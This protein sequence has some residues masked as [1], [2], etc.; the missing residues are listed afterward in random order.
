MVDPVTRDLNNHLRDIDQA[1]LRDAIESGEVE[2][3][4]D[5]CQKRCRPGCRF[6]GVRDCRQAPA[7]NAHV[8]MI[9]R[10]I[11]DLHT[12]RMA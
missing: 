10:N 1:E 8:H 7:E 9:F 12:R 11:L 3:P 4:C 6:Y 5:D 2:L